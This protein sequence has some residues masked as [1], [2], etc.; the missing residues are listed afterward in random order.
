MDK[1]VIEISG[2]AR[3]IQSTIDKLEQL[4]KVDKKNADSF[5]KNHADQQKAMGDTHK[6]V[7]DLDQAFNNLGRRI[8]TVLAVERVLAFGKAINY[9][10]W[11]Q[12][13]SAKIIKTDSEIC[14]RNP[15]P[16]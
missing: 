8:L 3:A 2:D 6:N 13:R 14:R 7:I 10:T 1:I 12:F 15:I 4:G 5:K 11:K 16:G 9:S